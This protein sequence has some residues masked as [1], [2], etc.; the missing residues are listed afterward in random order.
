MLVP[1]AAP[2][3]SVRRRPVQERGKRRFELILSSARTQLAEVGLDGFTLEG[4]AGAAG[5]PIGSVYQF[6]PNK[7]ALIA[8][9]SRVDTEALASELNHAAAGFDTAAWQEGT[10]NVIDGVA[11]LWRT[12]PTRRHVWLAMQS[13]AATRS[14]LAEQTRAVTD[15]VVPLVRPLLPPGS[16]RRLRTVAEVVVQ[17]CYSLLHFSVRDDRPHPSAVRELKRALRSYLRAVALDSS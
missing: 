6:F 1:M 11:E 17:M 12:D 14:L 8:E 2:D 10:D 9:L 13:T 4:V 5:V 15:E 16:T 7:H 3:L